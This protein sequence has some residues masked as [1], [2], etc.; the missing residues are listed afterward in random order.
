[1]PN[2]SLDKYIST[3]Q[4]GIPLLSWQRKYDIILGVARGIEYLHRGCD[5]RIFHFDIKPHNIPLDE[6]FI[7][8][9]SDFGLANLY[10]TDNSIVNLTAAR[11]TI[12]YVA[13]IDQQKHWSNLLQS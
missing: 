6:N 12:G 9:I 2:E 1:M 4:E 13:P 8:K 11:G 3:N 7:P 5:V 10:L